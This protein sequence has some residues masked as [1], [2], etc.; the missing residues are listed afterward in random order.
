MKIETVSLF[1][2]Y[3]DQIIT[4]IEG[5]YLT[6]DQI[7]F[8]EKRFLADPRSKND[9]YKKIRIHIWDT[10]HFQYI[11]DPKRWST[12]YEE[13]IKMSRQDE[14]SL[15]IFKDLIQNFDLGKLNL[16][17][18][19]IETIPEGLQVLDGVHRLAFFYYRWQRTVIERRFL[20]KLEPSNFH[21]TSF[22]DRWRLK[23]ELSRVKGSYFANSWGVTRDFP[24]GYHSFDIP[25]FSVKGQRDNR[26]RLQQIEKSITLEERSII[27]F[28]CN[29]G[30]MLLHWPNP[31]FA[32]GMDFDSK[33]ISAAKKIVKVL[34]KYDFEMSKRFEF[35]VQ[36]LEKLD[37][38]ELEK[39]FVF[40]KIDT[41][42]LL[43]IGS[44][45][46]SWKELYSFVAQF[47]TDIILETNNDSEGV[48]QIEFFKERNKKITLISSNSF[49]DNSGNYGRKT[50]LIQ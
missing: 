4:G 39:I 15:E 29:T 16:N 27:D 34:G 40:R 48:T 17:P 47:K 33:S 8:G 30:G 45:I 19:Y 11:N 9:K 21:I 49:D 20:S 37:F 5:R 22:F 44:W 42:L 25:G 50:Y 7:E 6:N 31:A 1:N 43:S 32:I 13:Y 35:Y 23:F 10:I 36:D 18:I 2:I 12:E 38:N 3:V 24:A 14:H 46:R 41:V 26:G 28:G